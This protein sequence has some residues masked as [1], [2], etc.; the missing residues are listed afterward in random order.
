MRQL[1]ATIMLPWVWLW[2]GPAFHPTAV[3]CPFL[4]NVVY[5]LYVEYDWSAAAHQ[6]ISRISK[7][8][9]K[10][11][12]LGPHRPLIVNGTCPV[13]LPPS[14]VCCC[15]SNTTLQGAITLSTWLQYPHRYSANHLL[16]LRPCI[17]LQEAA[18]LNPCGVR[19]LV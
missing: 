8:K 12:S 6:N 17:Q 14:S 2:A 5:F 9:K 13:Q 10:K 4:L 1:S 7:K 3:S 16:S 18:L 11:Q 15:S 19:M